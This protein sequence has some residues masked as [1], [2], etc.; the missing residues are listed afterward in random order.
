MQM[1]VDG[2]TA[3][4]NALAQVV[5][6]HY[7]LSGEGPNWLEPYAEL[8]CKKREYWEEAIKRLETAL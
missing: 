5:S 8:L 3:D 6:R 4:Q 2:Y 1:I 7:A